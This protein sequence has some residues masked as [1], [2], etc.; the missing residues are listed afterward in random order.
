M[1]CPDSSLFVTGAH[2]FRETYVGGKPLLSRTRIS[3]ARR[4][5]GDVF[6]S[7]S[8]HVIIKGRPSAFMSNACYYSFDRGD[9]CLGPKQTNL[10]PIHNY[11]FQTKVVLID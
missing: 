10:L 3:F 1:P 11:D 9:Q 2:S 6:D 5:G 4:S 7:Q 8:N